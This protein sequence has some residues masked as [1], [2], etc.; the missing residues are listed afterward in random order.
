[1]SPKNPPD[2]N[3]W[4]AEIASVKPLGSK[5]KPTTPTPAVP[6]APSKLIQQRAV[7]GWNDNPPIPILSNTAECISGLAPNLEKRLLK[8]LASGKIH[9]TAV[10]DLHG[11][12]EGD[13]WLEF[14]DFLHA[15]AAQ[16]HH[17]ALI[18]HGKG[19]GY[20]PQRNMGVIK[21]QIA[22]WLAGHPK[23]MAFHTALP[24]H[25]GTGATYAYLRRR[26]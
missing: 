14:V 1:M 18:I 10:V 20:G 25:G 3:A 4:L 23:V 5:G 26:I 13:A 19:Q 8:D 11:L 6:K 9:P 21:F 12:G 7:V 22:T 16:D 2:D 17:C 15:A 24:E